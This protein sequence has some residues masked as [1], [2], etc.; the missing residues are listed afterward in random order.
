MVLG[1]A[2]PHQDADRKNLLDQTR[3]GQRALAAA[4]YGD[5]IPRYT[6][7]KP[8]LLVPRVQGGTPWF[9]AIVRRK[10]AA[11][12]TRLAVLTVM[13]QG[14]DDWQLSSTSLLDPGVRAPA[15]TKD[16]DGYVT[17]LG[18]ED[19]TVE[20]SPRLMAPLHAT[21]AEEGAEGFAAGLIEDGPHT[22]GYATEIVKKRAA[23]KQ[24]CRGYDSIFAASD[25]P[26]H[27]LRTADGG[28]LILYSLIRTTTQTVK[29]GP[30]AAD[31]KVPPN[32]AKLTSD[33]F[34]L[35]ELRTVETQQYV[36]TVPAKNSGGPAR[37]IG[38]LGGVTKVTVS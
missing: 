29:I 2:T 38:Y 15:I 6:W 9:A 35:K 7:G 37:V 31:F 17:A 34:V 18:E 1:A 12:K 11:G 4:A 20:I 27:A 14:Q 32:L 26:V 3:D 21:S 16:A 22:T 5:T 13:R 23:E 25:Y 8:D 19:P 33:S 36:S 24:Q 28:A 30:C 10:D